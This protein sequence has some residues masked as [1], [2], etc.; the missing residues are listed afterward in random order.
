[1]LR[2]YLVVAA[3]RPVDDSQCI[4]VGNRDMIWADPYQGAELLVESDTR[5]WHGPL[6]HNIK[7]PETCE[8]S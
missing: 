3:I 1:M 4:R 6:P 2:T 5:P 7:P 8:A